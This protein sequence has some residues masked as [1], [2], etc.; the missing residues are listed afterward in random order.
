[1]STAA[2]LATI[3]VSW[4]KRTPPGYSL[5]I[6]RWI[7]LPATALML[8]YYGGVWINGDLRLSKDAI[9][10]IQTKAVPIAS[11]S[12]EAWSVP[13]RE[14]SAVTLSKGTVSDTIEIHHPGGVHK[15]MSARSEQ[16]VAQVRAA[17][18]SG[19]ADGPEEP[20]P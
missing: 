11:K 14:V 6:W 1:M 20:K 15:L 13:L 9:G 5:P 19:T 8:K 12:L 4:L 3:P 2:P 18:P 16:F 17:L 7:L 10:F